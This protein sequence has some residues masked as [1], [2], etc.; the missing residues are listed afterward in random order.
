[1]SKRRLRRF[2]RPALAQIVTI[3][4]VR[5]GMLGDRKNDDHNQAS[6]DEEINSTNSFA[7]T[8]IREQLISR[9][10]SDI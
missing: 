6:V 8:S 1:M 2:S 3:V 9:I 10:K 4:K 7:I 5:Y